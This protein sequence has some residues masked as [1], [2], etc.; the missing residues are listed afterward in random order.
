MVYMSSRPCVGWAWRPSPA[1]TTCT[2][3]RPMRRRCSVIRKGAPED[4]WRTTNRLACMATRLSMVSSRVSPLAVEDLLM[5]RLMTSAERRL[6]AISKVVRVRVEFSKN[7][8]KTLLPR[9]SGTFLTSRAETSM[10]DSAVSRIWFR[11]ALGR[12]SMDSRWASSPFL[13]NCGLCMFQPPGEL[14]VILAFEHQALAG[15]E[16]HIPGTVGGRDRQFATAA[17]G[18]HGE[19]DGSRAAVVEQL[20]DR[21]PR[22][23][24][25]VEHIIDQDDMAAF[26][27]ERNHG[28][29]ALRVQ[30]LL[31][32][33]ITVEGNIDQADL[34]G[35]AE[36]FLQALGNPGA[37]AVD[38]D[39]RR[40]LR[41]LRA[42]QVGQL[43]T[44]R[45]GIRQRVG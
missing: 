34:L 45:L 42:N 36:Q 28:W 8:L 37:A 22:R 2:S 41:E 4:A 17:I 38:A 1:L 30:T 3:S 21:R 10:K 24:A 29:P 16:R 18:Q 33:I 9:S 14:S 13:F 39:Q 5:S 44:L 12:P 27:I 6:A 32:E 25:G 40:V 31:G 7:R 26:D 43:A 23:A 11:M 19:F 20:V 15:A 35:Q